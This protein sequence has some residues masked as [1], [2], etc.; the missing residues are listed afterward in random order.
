MDIFSDEEITDFNSF[1]M[2][3][4]TLEHISSHAFGKMVDKLFRILRKEGV[5]K[6]VELSAAGVPEN[7]KYG[8]FAMA[9][10]LL[11]S[12]GIVN[13]EEEQ[14]LEQLQETLGIEADLATNIVEVI[15]IKNK[16]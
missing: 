3:A 5:V 12:D 15:V 11:F 10:D 16:V 13:Y 14:M 4:K 1:V 6:L 9:C 7:L 8:V 2:K